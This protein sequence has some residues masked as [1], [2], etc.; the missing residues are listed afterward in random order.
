MKRVYFIKPI[1]MDGPVKI[2]SSKYPSQRK[3]ALETWSPFPLHVVAEIEGGRELEGRFHAL[4]FDLH[5]RMEWFR[6]SPEIDRVID[7]INAGTFDVST[8]P[9]KINLSRFENGVRRKR[10]EYFGKQMSLV[11]RVRHMERRTGTRCPVYTYGIVREDN[12]EA[13]AQVEQ[14]LADPLR[15]GKPI[16][17]MWAKKA[18]RVFAGSAAA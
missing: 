14:Y 3:Y 11:L 13:I 5:E 15:H 17:V 12:Q 7:Q 16:D 9:E 6:A 18:R 10:P 1:G 4:F 8:L 2:G